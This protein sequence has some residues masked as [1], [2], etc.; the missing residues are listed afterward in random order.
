[1]FGSNAAASSAQCFKC[2]PCPP[3]FKHV[4]HW[5]VLVLNKLAQYLV[6]FPKCLRDHR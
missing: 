4:Y 2:P 5:L 3:A 1:M 6:V